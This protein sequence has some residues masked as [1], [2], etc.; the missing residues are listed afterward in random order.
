[1]K[2]VNRPPS[3]IKA[4][5]PSAEPPPKKKMSSSSDEKTKRRNSEEPSDDL[6]QQ[7]L[8]RTLA[9][10]GTVAAPCLSS[11]GDEE[12]DGD[13]VENEDIAPSSSEVGA[14]LDALLEGKTP[15][16]SS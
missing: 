6:L 14:A 9:G 5:G 8:S 3:K 11:S 1:M 15:V 16:T 2:N 12:E 10:K 7:Y 13:P 4:K